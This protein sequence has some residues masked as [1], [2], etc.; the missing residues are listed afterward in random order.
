MIAAIPQFL[1][2]RERDRN[3]STRGGYAAYAPHRARQMALLRGRGGE[4]LAVLGAGN[5]NDLELSTLAESFR[6][7]HLFDL[8]AQALDSAWCRQ[9][10]AVKRACSLHPC[11]LTGVG[12]LLEGWK[13]EPPEPLAAQLAAWTQ[14]SALA[15][16]VGEFDTV[17]SSCLLSQVAIDLRD[18]FG[19]V[20]ALNSALL[21]AI[22]GHVML[23]AALTKPGGAVL[24]TSDCIT[25]RYPIR[26]EAQARGALNAILHLASQGAA[27]PGTDPGL[28]ASLLASAEFSRPELKDAWIWDVGPQSYLVYALEAAR[29]P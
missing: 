25:S 29:H 11:D 10:N 21:A 4:R 18:Y 26:E 7:L 9:S 2:E 13:A 22:G 27:F 23:A 15:A 5:C 19:L 6:E 24:V 12:S 16:E 14:L 28:V 20:P 17:L 1:L 3:E 8:D